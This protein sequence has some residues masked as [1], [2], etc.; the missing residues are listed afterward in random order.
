MKLDFFTMIQ[1][2]NA[3]ECSENPTVHG[4]VKKHACHAHNLKP[5]FFGH[6]GIVHQ[7]FIQSGEVL[8][9]LRDSVRRK[10]PEL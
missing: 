9:I 10:R 1:K 3:T 4:T 2:Q 5:C 7:E 8:Q 6:T